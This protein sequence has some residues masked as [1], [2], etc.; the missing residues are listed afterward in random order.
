MTEGSVHC[1]PSVGAVK[2]AP[3]RSGALTEAWPL[4]ALVSEAHRQGSDTEREGCG[5]RVTMVNWRWR[6]SLVEVALQAR[7]RGQEGGSG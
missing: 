7:T 5:G 4:A 3:G 1:G 6:W 2:R